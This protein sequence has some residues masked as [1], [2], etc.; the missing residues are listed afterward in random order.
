MVCTG[1][2]GGG[3]GGL[4]ASL[5]SF[6]SEGEK[7]VTSGCRS[8]DPP[9]LMPSGEPLTFPCSLFPPTSFSICV[10]ALLSFLPLVVPDNLPLI[11]SFIHDEE[12][13]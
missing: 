13:K 10:N 8:K 9:P 11:T 5:R 12:N 7:R 3:G 4:L 1:G 2:G 6:G